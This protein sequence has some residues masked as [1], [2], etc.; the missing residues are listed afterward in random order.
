MQRLG[1]RTFL[2]ADRLSPII[3]SFLMPSH[4]KFDFA[5]FYQRLG[6]RGCVI[7][8]GKVSRADCFRIGTIGRLD[9]RDISR[10]IS[11]IEEV[12]RDMEVVLC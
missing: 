6:D 4:A 10:L 7:Y 3:T 1:F 9:K 8:P 12:L 5:R 2:T 11:A